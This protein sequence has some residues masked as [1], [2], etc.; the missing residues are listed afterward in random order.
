MPPRMEEGTFH[1]VVVVSQGTVIEAEE[2]APHIV[3]SEPE[4]QSEEVTVVVDQADVGV[5]NREVV[6]EVSLEPEL[7]SSSVAVEAEGVQGVV[8]LEVGLRRN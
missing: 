8:V 5:E 7:N 2:V 3:T 6:Y 1:Q 4:P